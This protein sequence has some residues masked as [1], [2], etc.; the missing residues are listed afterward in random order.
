MKILISAGAYL[1]ILE[2][3]EKGSSMAAP[4]VKFPLDLELVL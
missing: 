2:N 3:Q 4:L 1:G